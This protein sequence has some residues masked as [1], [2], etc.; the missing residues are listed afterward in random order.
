MTERTRAGLLHKLSLFPAS[1]SV[2]SPSI[3]LA[4]AKLQSR[5]KVIYF[6]EESCNEMWH[7]RDGDPVPTDSICCLTSPTL[8]A[9]CYRVLWSL[10][11]SLYLQGSQDSMQETTRSIKRCQL[12]VKERTQHRND[13]FRP[14]KSM[15]TLYRKK[16]MGR[17]VVLVSER[18]FSFCHKPTGRHLRLA[19]MLPVRFLYS[20]N[21]L[22][23]PGQWQ[24]RKIQDSSHDWS[25]YYLRG[26]LIQASIR[27]F[28][29]C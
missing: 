25:E 11:L 28:K 15:S 27:T 23:N 2:L 26:H 12:S 24:L 17:R 4:K 8:D 16:V 20:K 21:C 7:G 9:K 3:S 14:G 6:R 5:F 22:N 19:M 10:K 29:L 18:D 1:C 13:R